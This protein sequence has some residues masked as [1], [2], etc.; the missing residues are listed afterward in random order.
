[1]VDMPASCLRGGVLS[2]MRSLLAT[3]VCADSDSPGGY[4]ETYA[5][6]DTPPSVISR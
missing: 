4:V 2:G 3:T 1:M 5:D 6:E